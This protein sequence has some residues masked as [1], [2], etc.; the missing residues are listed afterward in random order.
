MQ[1]HLFQ[2][3]GRVGTGR[4]PTALGIN[5]A[6][7]HGQEQLR[8]NRGGDIDTKRAQLLATQWQRSEQAA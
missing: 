2:H 8:E 7:N 5:H 1:E 6:E 3:I 4:A